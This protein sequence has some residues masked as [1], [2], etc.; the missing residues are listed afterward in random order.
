MRQALHVA[1]GLAFWALLVALWVLLAL[2]GKTTGGAFRDTGVELAV[3]MGAVL[4][5]TLWWIRHNVGIHRR[6]GA[7]LGRPDLKPRT[8]EDRLGHVMHWA[9]EDGAAGAAAE[10]HLVIEVDGALKT[11]RRAS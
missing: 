5:V 1:I 9:L 11:Y 10:Q 6:K 7:R 3:L 4:V 2:E 8:D